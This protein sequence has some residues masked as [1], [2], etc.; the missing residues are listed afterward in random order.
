MFTGMFVAE[1]IKK[2]PFRLHFK[3]LLFFLDGKG[4][5]KFVGVLVTG[6]NQI[7]KFDMKWKFW[8]I[9]LFKFRFY[10]PLTGWCWNCKLLSSA[11]FFA[12]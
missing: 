10:C 7:W 12:H 9:F 6:G 4:I 1:G 5:S 3:C 11:A 2:I 8:E